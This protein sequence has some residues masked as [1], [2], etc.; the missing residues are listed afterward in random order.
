MTT[1]TKLD[2]PEKPTK[3]AAPTAPAAPLAKRANQYS[4]VYA[5]FLEQTKEHALTVALDDGLNRRFRVG[6]PETSIWSWHI[7][8]WPGY[9]AT[10]GDIAD[11]FMFTRIP[12]MLDFFEVTGGSQN[13]YS[14]GS[15]SIDF[16]YWAEKLSGGRSHEVRKY[17]SEAF[18]RHVTEVL[19][20][21]EDLGTEAQA[22][23][24]KI[25][26]VAKR[27]V[28]RHGVDYD[29]YLID[30]RKKTPT[31]TN[32]EI[33]ERD[34][35]EIELF[36]LSIPE[37]SP[38]E[39]RAECL[40]EA[41]HASETENDAY[42]WLRDN[43]EVFGVDYWEANL[44]DWDAHFLIAC[45][46][47]ELSVRLWREYEATPEAEAHRNPGDSYVLVDG[48]Q[49]QNGPAIPVFDLDVLNSTAPDKED[50]HG[51]LNLYES[52]IA[53]PQ[54]GIDLIDTLVAAADFVRRH[55]SAKD[56]SAMQAHEA[57][58]LVSK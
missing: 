50:A 25:V 21:H 22:E 11:G 28:T 1:S 20:E 36:G 40:D 6:D 52:I 30:L 48:G 56:V 33:N 14:D 37:E 4:S 51:A 17:S 18:I 49:V 13:Y 2:K 45:Y 38:A 8:T 16:R 10:F 12:D 31:L 58:R 44:R 23:Y 27:V 41:R 29:E 9:L 19:D 5:N 26:D 24:Q 55:G 32:L 7:V 39:R 46:A 3:P 35:D 53:H 15:P 54:A 47:L 43:Q 57:R 42:N 34:S